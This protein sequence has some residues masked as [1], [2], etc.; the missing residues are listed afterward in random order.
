M[1]STCKTVDIAEARNKLASV[2][3]ARKA[4]ISGVPNNILTINP[5]ATSTKIV[6]FNGFEPIADKIISHK[7]DEIPKN[8]GEDAIF[9]ANLVKEF[10][11]EAN[12]IRLTSVV[13]RGGSNLKPVPSGVYVI[14]SKMLEHALSE[15]KRPHPSNLGAPIAYQIGSEFGVPEGMRLVVNPVST[16]EFDPVSEISG[17]PEWPNRRAF[18]ALN[19]KIA[20][21]IAAN[22]LKVSYNH[23]NMVVAH[24]GAGITIAAHLRG[25]A[26]EVN[27][28]Q[29]E[30]FS[31]DASH[32]MPIHPVTYSAEQL[33][34]AVLEVLTLTTGAALDGAKLELYAGEKA[35]A[36]KVEL[37]N[38]IMKK[39][40]VMGELGTNDLKKV[41]ELVDS[42]DNHAIAVYGKLLREVAGNIGYQLMV[43]NGDV[44]AIVLTGGMTNSARFNADLVKMIEWT[45]KPIIIIPG[46]NENFAMAM[47]AME[48]IFGREAKSYRATSI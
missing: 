12:V 22:E 26:I 42:V 25:K 36:L 32:V 16:Y 39:G 7:P 18:H 5:G 9:R 46:D 21:K 47:G 10:L 4:Q 34:K 6:L 20:A 27:E 37:T 23:V 14:D 3:S 45:N 38:R 19:H 24:M 2:F 43:L 41:Y 30:I 29:G 33:K 31:M 15:G 40:G 35:T 28:R 17:V 48:V 13:G 11:K 1:A 8:P 44:D